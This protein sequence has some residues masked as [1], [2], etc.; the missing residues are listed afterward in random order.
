MVLVHHVL[1][2][3]HAH[4]GPHVECKQH[5]SYQECS[6]EQPALVP[7]TSQSVRHLL[8]DELTKLEPERDWS[9]VTRQ[10]GAPPNRL[11]LTAHAL[12]SS[13]A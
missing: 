8:Y 3:V 9:F 12:G 6:C 11:L 2:W 5:E 4:E 10:I 13:R 7:T 1:L